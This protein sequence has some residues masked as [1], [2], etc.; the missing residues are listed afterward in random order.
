[1]YPLLVTA[2]IIEHE[3]KLLLAKRKPDAP[4]PHMWEFPGGKIEPMEDPRD[5]VIREVREELGIGIEVD[6]IYDVIYH[7]YPERTVLIMAYRC[8][9]LDGEV[10]ELDVAGYCWVLPD[11]LLSYSLL[12]ADI[13]LAERLSMEFRN[14]H[15]SC[16]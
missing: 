12:P 1:M 14:A 16:V 7:H 8:R 4:Y 15:P 3:G 9:W 6:G 2:A 13:P 5:C 11:D 10:R